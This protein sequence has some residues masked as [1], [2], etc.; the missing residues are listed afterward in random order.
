[1]NIYPYVYKGVHPITGEFYI[2]MR[3]ANKLPAEHRSKISESI[4]KRHA[5][6]NTTMSQAHTGKHLSAE[7]RKS[8]SD[9]MRKKTGLPPRI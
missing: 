2:G 9:G 6:G 7:H 1:M 8:I 4:K 5:D 3:C